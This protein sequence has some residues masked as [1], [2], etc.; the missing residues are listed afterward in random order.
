MSEVIL[1]IN[2]GSTSTKVAIFDGEIERVRKTLRHSD[3]DLAK[4]K[5]MADQHPYREKI[6]LEFLSENNIPLESLDVVVGRGGLIEPVVGGIYRIND[7]MIKTLSTA[8]YGEHASNLGALIAKSIADR[9]NI[10]SFII[11]PVV[12]DE[13]EILSRYAGNPLFERHSIFHALNQKSVG[14]IIAAKLNKKYEECNFV[15]A[16]IG[17]GVTVGAHKN[18]K[19]IDVTNGLDGEGPFSPERSGGLPGR[20]IVRYCFSGKY[21]EE[22]MHKMITGKGGILSYLGTI[23]MREVEKRSLEG[24][25]KYREVYEAMAYQIAKAI[26]EMSVVLEGKIDRIIITG[27][28][29]FDKVFV[30]W[31]TRR[32]SFIAPIEV[33]PGEEELPPLANAGL[34][35]LRGTE[36]AKEYNPSDLKGKK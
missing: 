36:K 19:V 15:I 20:Q 25:K 28:V 21:T 8:K 11:D 7:E 12:V 31:I 9:V 24:D 3:A 26:G 10:P 23:D 17:G 14:R 2:P 29:A 6:V 35:I 5:K 32:V 4:Y 13:M 33:Y 34:R 16:H 18:G 27:G 1:V 30:S 22:E